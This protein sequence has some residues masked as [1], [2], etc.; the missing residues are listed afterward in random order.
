MTLKARYERRFAPA[1]ARAE[2]GGAS[3][4]P[5][6]FAIALFLLLASLSLYEITRPD[7]AVT[8]LAAGVAALTDVDRTLAENL[9]L[10]RE[11]AAAA[12][13]DEVEPP[14]FPLPAAIPREDALS[15][16]A[17]VLRALI[18]RSAAASLYENGLDSLDRT[19]EQS[20]DLFS[21]T[22]VMR[23]FAAFL[24]GDAHGQARWLAVAA[25]LAAT[26]LGAATLALNRGFARFRIFGGA[27]LLAAAP[28]YLAARGASWLLDRFA[29]DDA[30]VADLQTVVQAMLA[31]PA[32]NFL[33]AGSLGLAIVVVG[34]ALGYAAGYLWPE[35]APIAGDE[36]GP[37]VPFD[38]VPGPVVQPPGVGPDSDQPWR[39]LLRRVRLPR[40]APRR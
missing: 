15:A 24:T 33:I 21:L 20:A 3:L 17:P 37:T 31:V 26:L 13:G 11:R 28:G 14:G 19:G 6:L 18:L 8:I 1:H 29:S 5:G 23:G 30:F 39:G 10:L 34:W 36:H 22:S 9:P 27:V 12:G 7:R 25:L 4:A 2:R 40:A 38:A 35:D 32:R 16:D